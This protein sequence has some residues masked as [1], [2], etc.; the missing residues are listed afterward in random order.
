MATNGWQLSM[1]ITTV[2]TVGFPIGFAYDW[3]LRKFIANEGY[4]F[5]AV[6]VEVPIRRSRKTRLQNT[7]DHERKSTLTGS[8]TGAGAGAEVLSLSLS[9]LMLLWCCC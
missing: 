9:L 2:L 7:R 5:E 4:I 1:R 3:L 8:A 6:R